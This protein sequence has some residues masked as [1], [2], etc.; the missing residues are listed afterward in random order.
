MDK[1][2]DQ[3][4]KSFDFSASVSQSAVWV[5]PGISVAKGKSFEADES[6]VSAISSMR[7]GYDG[8]F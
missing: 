1:P 6:E 4:G 5:S 8:S 2:D 7:E 3:I